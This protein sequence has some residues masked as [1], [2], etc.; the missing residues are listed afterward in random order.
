LTGYLLLPLDPESQINGRSL[1][2]FASAEAGAVRATGRLG[3]L[4]SAHVPG[5][6]GSRL[7]CRGVL[8]FQDDRQV[9]S[10]LPREIDYDHYHR[11]PLIH[12]Q[13]CSGFGPTTFFYC[14]DER[15]SY[16]DGLPA[17]R[18]ESSVTVTGPTTLAVELM[19]ITGKWRRFE[20]ALDPKAPLV[21]PETRLTLP[22]QPTTLALNAFDARLSATA[23][24]VSGTLQSAAGLLGLAADQSVPIPLADGDAGEIVWRTDR[25]ALKRTVG[26][27]PRQAS[28][29]YT[30]G[31]W[32]L[33]GKD[34]GSLPP[35]ALI[36]EP[37][38]P[39]RLDG[40][41]EYL[42]PVLRFGRDGLYLH[43][44]KAEFDLAGVPQ[45]QQV[46]L[47]AWSYVKNQW[48]HWGSLKAAGGVALDY[49]TP[50]VAARDLTPPVIRQ[51]LTHPYFTGPRTVIPLA[52]RGSGID[53]DTIRITGREGSVVNGLFDFD[54]G[55][56]ILPADV[57]GP[58]SVTVS[59]KA[60]L[61][62]RVT[63]LSP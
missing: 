43:G 15:S 38:D 7:G 50:I 14:F 35:Q 54:R 61:T 6:R 19:D 24:D 59:D 51:P 47:Y 1:P 20:L 9:G 45:P 16:L 5:L 49:F 63:D 3:V 57:R 18:Q 8:L 30:I 13:A 4:V 17:Y 33:R 23:I 37:A 28:F 26:S 60:G 27:L 40:V 11:G 42:S 31:P 48:R 58:Y 32:T 29:T 25:G 2:H 39:K 34:V 52:D 62:T 21:E 12:D 46:G 10:W 56:V 41:L 53:E 44:L 22:T 55:W 36:L